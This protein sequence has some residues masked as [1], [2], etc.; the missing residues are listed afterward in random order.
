M[1]LI[2]LMYAIFSSSFMIGKILLGICPPIFLTGARMFTGGTILL[3]YQYCWEHH[4]FRLKRKHIWLFAQIILLGIYF[5]YTLRF[6]GL[7]YLTSSKTAFFYNMSPFFSSFYSYIFF[8]ETIS[9]KQWVGL[10][11]G[12]LGLIPILIS[13]S[14]TEQIV[15][16]WF[17]ISWPELAILCSVA[18]HSYSWIVVRQLVRDKSYTPM[19]VNGVTMSCGGLLALITSFFV[20]G[21]HPIAADNLM[22]FTTLLT[23]IIITSNIICYN[24]YGHLLKHYSATFLSFAGFLSPMFAA[25]YGWGF[26]HET[27]SWHFYLSTVIVF[28]GLYLFYQDELKPNVQQF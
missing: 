24:M 3:V 12:F 28:I 2:I 4:H 6:W 25:L 19:M 11:I 8:K 21:T 5:T 13:S 10:M 17:F 16:E 15:G 22:T 14:T 1:T 20:E 27:I 18:A 7:Q 9:K 23:T 26:L